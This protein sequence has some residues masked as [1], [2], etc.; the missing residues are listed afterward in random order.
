MNQRFSYCF[1]LFKGVEAA[2]IP[3]T[4]LVMV[5]WTKGADHFHAIEYYIIEARVLDG[6]WNVVVGRLNESAQIEIG[7]ST[8]ILKKAH[9]YSVEMSFRENW[10]KL[11]KINEKPRIT[12]VK[13]VLYYLCITI[14]R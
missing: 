13:H 9:L 1:F 6:P 12:R 7:K 8:V 10:S 2:T 5:N 14:R 4:E 3:D 11:N